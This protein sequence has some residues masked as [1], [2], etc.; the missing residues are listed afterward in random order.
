MPFQKGHPFYR[1]SDPKR[2]SPKRPTGTYEPV[3][4]V[5]EGLTWKPAMWGGRAA[6][7]ITA[8]Y[9]LGNIYKL[10]RVR[11]TG[12]VTYYKL[13]DDT[14]ATPKEQIDA[15]PERKKQ[16]RFRVGSQCWFIDTTGH[17]HLVE[18]VS[19]EP[20]R[21]V[22]KSVTGWDADREVPWEYG[23]A[24]EFPTSPTNRLFLRLRKLA[25]RYK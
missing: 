23:E 24:L 19:R 15:E 25:D 21:I 16:Q 4:S 6:N 18:V 17:W 2:Y 8:M 3:T 1:T 7:N 20:S 14:T 12:A 9:S 22:I 11:A 10:V 13:K 5:P